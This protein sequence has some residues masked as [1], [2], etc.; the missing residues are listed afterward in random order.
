MSSNNKESPK[1]ADWNSNPNVTM[2]LKKADWV[3][4]DKI[5]MSC[6]DS[7]DTGK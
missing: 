3:P 6:K 7:A 2:A 4:N 5:V 1:K